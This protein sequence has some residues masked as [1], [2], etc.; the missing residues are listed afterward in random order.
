MQRVIYCLIALAASGA[1]FAGGLCGLRNGQVSVWLAWSATPSDERIPATGHGKAMEFGAGGRE[2]DCGT[3]SCGDR[4]KH[5]LTGKPGFITIR[6]R[7]SRRP[8]RPPA[9]LPYER[10]TRHVLALQPA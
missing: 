2:L 6:G 10:Q 5:M 8:S 3:M 7:K 9:W 1:G 4:A